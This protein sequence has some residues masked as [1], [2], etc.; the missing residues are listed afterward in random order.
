MQSILKEQHAIN[1]RH[2]HCYT[3]KF[4][5]LHCSDGIA[6]Q[7]SELISVCRHSCYV[8]GRPHHTTPTYCHYLPGIVTTF[9]IQSYIYLLNIC[10][11]TICCT[12]ISRFICT[13]CHKSLLQI[14]VQSGVS[15]YQTTSERPSAN[16]AN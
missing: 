2:C 11:L 5:S 16:V 12:Y 6:T 3:I 15:S 9:T 14:S 7:G 10:M 4:T 13:E 8:G 1:Y